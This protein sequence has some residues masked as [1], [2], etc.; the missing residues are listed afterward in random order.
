MNISNQQICQLDKHHEHDIQ[1]INTKF[2]AVKFTY[3]ANIFSKFQRNLCT[4]NYIIIAHLIYAFGEKKG[5]GYFRGK[6]VPLR[7]VP[8]KQF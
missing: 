7:N 4:K 1:S 6:S 5:E 2:R 3:L 8:P